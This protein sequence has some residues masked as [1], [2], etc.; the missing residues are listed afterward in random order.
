VGW[1]DVLIT[2]FAGV[3]VVVGLWIV[4]GVG[5]GLIVGG[6]GVLVLHWLVVDEG[7]GGGGY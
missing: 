6:L 5:W 4:F 7:S 2:G 3:A 1:L